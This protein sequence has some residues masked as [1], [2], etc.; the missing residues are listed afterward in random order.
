MYNYV[1]KEKK[2]VHFTFILDP[3]NISEKCIDVCNQK[4]CKS[5]SN[6]KNGCNQM[7][8]CPNAC[9]IRHLGDTKDECLK[10]CNRQG[11]SGCS[12]TVNGYQFALCGP[13][14]RN[15]CSSRDP[16]VAECEI[17]CSTYDE[18]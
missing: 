10:H 6:L 12:A 7:F 16:T 1:S 5:E 17:G 2:G 18:I 3:I 14:S 8:T 9:Q 13:C 11:D 15:G 4:A